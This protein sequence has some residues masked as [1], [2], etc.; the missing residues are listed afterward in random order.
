M[1][2]RHT[3]RQAS[4]LVC[5]R[6]KDMNKVCGCKQTYSYVWTDVHRYGIAVYLYVSLRNTYVVVTYQRSAMGIQKDQQN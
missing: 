1:I 6:I 2:K 3:D 5:T 4:L